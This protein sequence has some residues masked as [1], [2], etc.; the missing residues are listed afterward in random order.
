MA[1]SGSLAAMRASSAVAKGV[2]VRV[3][4]EGRSG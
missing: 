2:K 1:L 4:E 3:G